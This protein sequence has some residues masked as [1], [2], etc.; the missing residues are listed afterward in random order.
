MSDLRKSKPSI[1]SA[2]EFDTERLDWLNLAH[3]ILDHCEALARLIPDEY[4][5]SE[6]VA[7]SQRLIDKYDSAA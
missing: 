4:V 6:L 2:L 7:G 1:M 3:T 5:R